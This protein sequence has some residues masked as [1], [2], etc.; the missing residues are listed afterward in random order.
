LKLSSI[1]SISSNVKIGRLVKMEKVTTD[2]NLNVLNIVHDYDILGYKI[3]DNS[4]VKDEAIVDLSLTRMQVSLPDT[5]DNNDNLPQIGDRLRV[6]FYLT[7]S[8]DTELIS[9]TKSG[10]QVT[11]KT[12]LLVDTIAISS[13]FTSSTSA[14]A[15]LTISNFNQPVT[16][17]R[18]KTYYDYLAPKVNERITVTF[19]YNKMISDSTLLI[20]DVRLTPDMERVRNGST[21]LF[22]PRETRQQREFLSTK[23]ATVILAAP[24]KEL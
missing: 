3:L 8:S 2:N 16:K 24:S 15:I 4:F 12:Y 1:A 10:T 6:R 5:V 11:N 22:R 14:G 23:N 19:N 13:G 21:Q 20:E 18:Y 7:T 17:S 9:F